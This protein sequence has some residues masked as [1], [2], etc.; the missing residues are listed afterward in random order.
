MLSITRTRAASVIAI[1]IAT[2]SVAATAHAYQRG[3][4]PSLV[5]L[6][7]TPS[8]TKLEA[9]WSVAQGKPA[10]YRVQK[11]TSNQSTANPDYGWLKVPGSAGSKGI[12]TVLVDP[13]WCA[14]NGLAGGSF[15]W[16]YEVTLRNQWG[17]DTKF[18]LCGGDATYP[19]NSVM[20]TRPVAAP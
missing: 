14:G 2:A 19:P 3:V 20:T 12:T 15:P 1:F 6:V 7:A 4:G 16:Y 13:G 5:N 18:Y 17:S 11:F 9:V 10:E 8:Q